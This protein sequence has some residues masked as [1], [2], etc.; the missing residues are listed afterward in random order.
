MVGFISI[1]LTENERYHFS[2]S[3][4]TGY[5]SVSVGIDLTNLKW[6]I[7]ACFFAQVI[8][9]AIFECGTVIELHRRSNLSDSLHS[10]G[11]NCVTIKT[12]EEARNLLSWASGM[13]LPECS[14]SVAKQHP[15][16]NGFQTGPYHYISCTISHA[17]LVDTWL[18]RFVQLVVIWKLIWAITAYVR[19]NWITAVYTS[20]DQSMWH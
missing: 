20:R 11:K 18:E 10:S 2:P 8:R 17:S 6:T 4:W 1:L 3:I 7:R 12:S 16:T 13:Q 9:L 14:W 5:Y 15:I 19:K